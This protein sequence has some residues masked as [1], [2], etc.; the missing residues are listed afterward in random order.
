[1]GTPSR[2]DLRGR[3][4]L[5]LRQGFASQN[6]CVAHPRRGRRLGLQLSKLSQRLNGVGQ[7]PEVDEPCGVVLVV[8]ALLEGHQVLGVQALREVTEEVMILPL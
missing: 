6:A 1:M 2:F 5:P 8:V 7:T 3:T 4:H